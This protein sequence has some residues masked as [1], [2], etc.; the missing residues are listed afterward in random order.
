MKE[1]MTMNC[2]NNAYIK[3][4]IEIVNFDPKVLCTDVI[5]ASTE[6]GDNLDIMNPGQGW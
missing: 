2:E 4:E 3:P 1:V 6:P 5:A